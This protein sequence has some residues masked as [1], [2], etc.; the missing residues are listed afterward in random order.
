MK[1]HGRD[2]LAQ[3]VA[4]MY[5]WTGAETVPTESVEGAGPSMGSG[6][7]LGSG[8]HCQVLVGAW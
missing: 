2:S 8:A 7:R 4:P 1:G 5:G 3:A 6:Q